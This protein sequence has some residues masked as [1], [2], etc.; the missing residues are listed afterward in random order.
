MYQRILQQKLVELSANWSV[1]SVTG[2]R[3]SGKT[4]LCKMAFPDYQYV[5]LER[6]TTC[7]LVRKDIEGYLLQYPHGLIID[8]AQNLPE[9]FSALQV[10]VDEHKDYRYIL[11]GSSDFLLMQNITQ[12]LAGRVAVLRLLPLSIQEL[13]NDA[14]IP[15]DELL[16]RGF[17]PAVW[18]DGKSP[19]MVYDSYVATYIQRDVRQIQNVKDLSLFQR[20]L[21]L[22]ASRVGNMFVAS[23]IGSELGID[24]KTI[25]AW[26]SILET[27]YT[28]FTLQ[29][30]Y[31][32]I[33]KRLTK[34]PKVY[35]YDVGLVSYLLG[36]TNVQQLAHH[37]L[38]GAI[39]ENMVVCELLK[40]CYNAGHK[41][42]LSFYRDQSQEV[43]IIQE[44]AQG[45]RA[46]EIKSSERFHADFTK[47]LKHLQ[48]LLGDEI[49]S[50][51]VVYAGTEQLFTQYGGLVNYL[52]L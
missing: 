35:F 19:D 27:S 51:K 48:T 6:S 36:I 30:F 10:V 9:L 2:P 25:Q 52:N 15:T 16:W 41:S 47:A 34:T 49:V 1:I 18:G 37:P 32:N 26:M 46:I 45:I 50:S 8:E 22:L 28:A 17:Y 12:S 44:E 5:N 29:P 13:G 20:F 42:N 24:Y 11:S 40:G 21:T 43:D 31:R 3:Q 7:E 38:R 4:T 33:G 39:F 23:S 14:H